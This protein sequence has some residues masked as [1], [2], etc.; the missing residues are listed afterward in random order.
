MKVPEDD[1]ILEL[2]ADPSDQE[3]G[4]KLMMVKYQKPLY[5]HIRRMVKEHEDANDVLQNTF[6]KVY[7]NIERF[8]SK[9][10]L[11]TWLYKIA[12]NESI[13]FLNKKKRIKTESLETAELVKESKAVD[14]QDGDLII[15]KLNSAIDKLPEKQRMVFSMRYF[16]EMTYNQIS[17]MLGTSVGGLKA[18]YH[19]AV[20]KIE[21]LI[22][23]G[24]L[25]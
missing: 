17:E 15:K 14:S 22:L 21:T 24:K 20:K 11:Y 5:W 6:I 10:K 7:K 1:E 13:T 25:N 16:D 23:E 18:S 2:I 9:S 3:R 4:F 8:E 12:T 19:H